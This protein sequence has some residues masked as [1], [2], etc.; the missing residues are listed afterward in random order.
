V[1]DNQGQGDSAKVM[2]RQTTVANVFKL[3]SRRT[4]DRETDGPSFAILITCADAGVPSLETRRQL[5]VRIR[6]E[7][8][9]APVFTDSAYFTKIVENNKPGAELLRVRATDRD[10]GAN[11]NVTYYVDY[12]TATFADVTEE[13]VIIAVTSFDREEAEH[14]SFYVYATDKGQPPLSASVY[15]TIFVDDVNDE[16]PKFVKRFYTFSVPENQPAGSVV[17][18]VTARDS[19]GTGKGLVVYS[20]FSCISTSNS[21]NSISSSSSSSSSGSDG[22][23]VFTINDR[24]GQVVTT[25]ALDREVQDSYS[26]T[27]VAADYLIPS[28]FSTVNVSIKVTDV[29]DN[30]PEFEMT[31]STTHDVTVPCNAPPGHVVTQM[32]ASDVDEDDN[33]R[34]TFAVVRGSQDDLFAIKAQES[35][36]FV[37]ISLC[38]ITSLCGQSFD[39]VIGVTDNGQPPLTSITSL[40]LRVNGSLSRDSVTPITAAAAVKDFR[41]KGNELT[42]V[43]C[44]AALVMALTLTVG[45]LAIWCRRQRRVRRELVRSQDI[46]PTL[47]TDSE[48]AL[49]NDMMSC[50]STSERLHENHF[51]NGAG[52]NR[53]QNYTQHPH[54][55]GD[56]KLEHLPQPTSS[57]LPDITQVQV[58]PGN[59][60]S[61]ETVASSD[62]DNNNARDHYFN[63]THNYL[64]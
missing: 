29:N 1:S 49:Y 58:T 10:I 30:A 31:S 2:L 45:I 25:Q 11:G 56:L 22:N 16:S 46:P 28:L 8:D 63:V 62:N 60:G 24:T 20:L 61:N 40:Y 52:R 36:G 19:D 18:S 37:L 27:V 48:S 35:F 9:N 38:D 3:A 17:G 6:D 32:N 15:V 53:K 5:T 59:H 41:L 51:R 33:A 34:L 13:G 12:V 26:L 50:R 44:S 64:A 14:V 23:C 57:L 47:A 7:N 54:Q 43:A 4:F 39:L 42:A 21:N 55:E